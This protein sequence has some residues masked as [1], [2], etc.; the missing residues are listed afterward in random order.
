MSE[1]YIIDDRIFNIK[2]SC[3][4][5]KCK[6][7]CCT[8]KGAGGAPLLN[9]EV[10]IIKRN[11]EIAKKYL[12]PVNIHHIETEGV[13]EGKED[14]YSLK[15]VN[16]EECIFSFYEEGIAKC[17]F[18]KAYFNN[19]TVFQKPIS[20][21]LFPV[22]ISGKKR[23]VLKYEEISECEDALSKGKADGVTIFEFAKDALVR[24]YGEQFYIDLKNKYFNK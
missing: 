20:C 18:Q 6:G 15:S 8:L 17:A 16:D 12:S 2:F 7:A 9:E 14:D 24:E 13:I 19:E 23:N 3:D 5:S 11:T 4:V 21:H 10:K 22:R 1:K